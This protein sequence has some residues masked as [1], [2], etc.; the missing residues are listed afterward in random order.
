MP[1]WDNSPSFRDG[2]CN[3][4]SHAILEVSVLRKFRRLL[5]GAGVKRV[6]TTGSVARFSDEVVELVRARAPSQL[7]Q[8][9]GLEE[10]LQS[11]ASAYRVPLRLASRE[12][13]KRMNA[14]TVEVIQAAITDFQFHCGRRMADLLE[15]I[16]LL[17][18]Q[19]RL[20]SALLATRAFVELCAAVAYLEE[21]V[22][23]KLVSGIGSQAEL[24]EATRVLD[25]MRV[26]GRFDWVRFLGK[27]EE[28]IRLIEAYAKGDKKAKKPTVSQERVGT[29]IESLDKRFAKVNP[30]E[31]GH[32]LLYYSMLSDMCHPAVGATML[33]FDPASPPG[34]LHYP[35]EM[36]DH[37]FEF[38]LI[39][40]VLP[41]ADRAGR[42]AVDG[43][44]RL[45]HVAKTLESKP[46]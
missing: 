7:P 41:I 16:I 34:W 27:E 38:C 26:G 22:V 25:Q 8:L 11:F 4:A 10:A 30:A 13:M 40:V 17:I 45:T 3:I 36:T 23:G 42:H 29:M 1:A 39:Q 12:T 21:K 14:M 37:A 31:G 2:K 24:N 32:A 33:Y 9:Q 19:K 6:K 46:A 20:L 15:D 43:L 35:G 18:N 28:R 5:V 44:N